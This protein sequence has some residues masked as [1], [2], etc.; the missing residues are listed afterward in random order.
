MPTKQDVLE[1]QKR[2]IEEAKEVD[3]ARLLPQLGFTRTNSKGNGERW[4]RGNAKVKLF[5][6][7][8]GQSWWKSFDGELNTSS[9]NIV[10]MVMF[11]EGCDYRRA[12]T[13]V[14]EL[15]GLTDPAVDFARAK[16]SVPTLPP[17]PT[18]LVNSS[19]PVEPKATS[20]ELLKR[21]TEACTRWRLDLPVPSYLQSRFF[22]RVP[23]VF[24][25]CFGVQNGGGAMPNLIFPYFRYEEGQLSMAGYE[26]KGKDFQRYS[27]GGHVGFW[28]SRRPQPDAPLLI[29]EAPLDAM[30]YELCSD[31]AMEARRRSIQLSYLALRSGAAEQVGE[32]IAR[33]SKEGLTRV[34]MITDNDAAGLNYA[35]EVMR[36]VAK[37]QKADEIRP[38]LTCRYIAPTH[39]QTDWADVLAY[40][41]RRQQPETPPPPPPPPCYEPA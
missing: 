10:D 5:R 35:S 7:R 29:A 25:G 22:D 36:E 20:E 27:K 18:S 19:E 14:R 8:G 21:Y 17:S 30:A 41:A 12:C 1:L 2:Q 31:D 24:D 3:L 4:D 34:F 11:V 39:F 6:G 32:H 33:L 16:T 15:L 37:R 26:R 38:D 9:G 40:L 23:R 13:R 28:K